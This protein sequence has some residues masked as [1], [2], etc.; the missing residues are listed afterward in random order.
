M[1]YQSLS[2]LMEEWNFPS[3]LCWHYHLISS[4][5]AFFPSSSNFKQLIIIFYVAIMSIILC[6]NLHRFGSND[7]SSFHTIGPDEY[8]SDCEAANESMIKFPHL[9]SYCKNRNSSGG[10]KNR[11]QTPSK[12]FIL[13]NNPIRPSFSSIHH[14]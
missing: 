6:S 14:V 9:R 5:L 7:S 2:S 10:Q 13:W 1:S 3:L 4:S 8:D 11:S 12:R